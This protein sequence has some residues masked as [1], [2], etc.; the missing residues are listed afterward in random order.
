MFSLQYG[1]YSLLLFFICAVH[2]V[3][4]ILFLSTYGQCW[5]APPYWI[6]RCTRTYI[7]G[8]GDYSSHPSSPRPALIGGRNKTRSP[9]FWQILLEFPR[10]GLIGGRNK[11]RSSTFW[12]ILLEFPR[13]A[14]IGGRN[15]THSPT[16]SRILLWLW[17][18]IQSFFGRITS[19]FKIHIINLCHLC[20]LKIEKKVMK[21][22]KKIKGIILVE[23]FWGNNFPFVWNRIWTQLHLLHT[24]WNFLY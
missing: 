9:T 20:L 11:T 14:L 8:G 18:W 6:E 16:F 13:L 12:Q 4:Y 7:R 21:V 24:F 3:Q 2:C 15:K 10:P 17:N 23:Y 19:D 5:S 1:N 22:M